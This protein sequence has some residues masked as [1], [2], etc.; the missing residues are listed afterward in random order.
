MFLSPVGLKGIAILELYTRKCGGMTLK[1]NSTRG[2]GYWNGKLYFLIALRNLFEEIER[3]PFTRFRNDLHLGYKD[4]EVGKYAWT[5][6]DLT[7]YTFNLHRERSGVVGWNENRVG[8]C[9]RRTDL[10]LVL[11]LERLWIVSPKHSHTF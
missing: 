6:A 1:I 3:W 8:E 10:Y 2:G 7:E 11:K 9:K 5:K 4:N